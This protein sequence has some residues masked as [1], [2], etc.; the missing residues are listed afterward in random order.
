MKVILLYLVF[1][2]LVF[3]AFQNVGSIT[4]LVYICDCTLAK[5]NDVIVTAY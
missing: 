2:K 5:K 1:E 3:G 4:V